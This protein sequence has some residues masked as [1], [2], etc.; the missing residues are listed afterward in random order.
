MSP[1]PV[2]HLSPRSLTVI[3]VAGVL[4]IGLSARSGVAALSPLATDIDLDVPIRGTALGLLGMIPP[5][6]YG[7]AGL[8][9]RRLA[10]QMSLELLALI[11]TGIAATGHLARGLAPNFL[12]L[13][14]ATVTLMLAVGITNVALPALVKLYA[15][16]RIG[17]VTSSYTMLMSVSTAMPA[18]LGVWFADQFGW[19]WSLGS[20]AVLSFLAMLPWFILLPSARRRRYEEAEALMEVPEANPRMRLWSSAT[21]RALAVTFAYSSFSSYIIFAALPSIMMEQA[22]FSRDEAGFALFVWSIV[23]VFM[24][25]SIPL[26]TVRP[27]WPP[28]LIAAAGVTGTA[29]FLGLLVVPTVVPLVWVVLTALS[30]LT[31]TLMLTLIPF[32]SENHVT[33]TQL[34]GLVQT[35]GYLIAGVGPLLVGFLHDLAQSWWPGLVLMAVAAALNFFAVPVFRRTTSIEQELR[36]VD[37]AQDQSLGK[38]ESD[39]RP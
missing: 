11:V 3:G 32:R 33:A 30:T 1:P 7:L 28:R 16:G 36:E 39:N 4:L 6:A 22:G 2:S 31:F 9:A 14:L 17:I 15:P 23:G 27:G 25:L 26:L 19:R 8:M 20:W 18:L 12:G 10:K 37:Q 5:I 38:P 21:V 13:F 24:S 35:F 34:S 29:G